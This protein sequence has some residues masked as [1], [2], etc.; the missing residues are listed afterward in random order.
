M[1]IKVNKKSRFDFLM[2]SFLTIALISGL[3]LLFLPTLQRQ[4]FVGDELAS[5]LSATGHL[6]EYRTLREI[7][8]FPAGDWV[9][10]SEW[11]RFLQPESGLGLK[12][13]AEDLFYWDIHPPLYFFLLYG[14]LHLFAANQWWAGALLN[15]VITLGAAVVLFH[16]AR[17]ITN[18]RFYAI[19]AVVI[20]VLSPVFL[21]AAYLTRQYVLLTFWTVLITW[22][23]FRFLAASSTKERLVYLI[24][25]VLVSIAG[26]LTQYIFLFIIIAVAIVGILGNRSHRGWYLW[27]IISLFAGL[28]LALVV[29]VVSPGILGALTFLTEQLNESVILWERLPKLLEMLVFLSLP[30]LIALLLIVGVQTLHKFTPI[31][32]RDR[33]MSAKTPRVN[34]HMIVY[35]AILVLLPYGSV[36]ILYMLGIMPLHAMTSRYIM[37]LTPFVALITVALIANFGGNRVVISLMIVAMF[38]LAIVTSVTTFR[39]VSSMGR[40]DTTITNNA[41]LVLIDRIHQPVFFAHLDKENLVYAARPSFLLEHTDEWLPRL[42]SEGGVYISSVMN[43]PREPDSNFDNRD[44]IISHIEAQACLAKVAEYD[45]P[46]NAAI[47]IYRIWN[48]GGSSC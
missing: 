13:I 18:D 12:K 45:G 7:N 44:K 46:N 42:T 40:F 10:A 29:V 23:L 39:N 25:F 36:I 30:I 33:N 5:F 15:L 28:S 4:L 35:L 8:S 43:N 24:S 41:P 20:W 22:V 37:Y 14:W 6:G 1:D 31:D 9:Q 17:Q 16:L 11:Q 26:L 19:L 47:S 38:L 48:P 3:V 27:L 2:S 32:L 34:N 21:R